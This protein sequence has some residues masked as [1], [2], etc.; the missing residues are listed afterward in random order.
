MTTKAEYLERRQ[1]EAANLAQSSGRRLGG[2]SPDWASHVRA[3][4]AAVGVLVQLPRLRDLG[5]VRSAAHAAR[6]GIDEPLLARVRALLAQAESTSFE[7]EAAAFMAKA[8]ELMTRYRIDRAVVE[9]DRAQQGGAPVIDARRCWLDDPYLSLESYLLSV[10]ARANQVRAVAADK[11]GFVTLVGHPADVD[12]TE[13]LFTSL[14]V[15]ATRRMAEI[16]A[17][18]QPAGLGLFL[19]VRRQSARPSYRRSFFVGFANRIGDR[20][21]EA[22]GASSAAAVS[23]L[24]ETFLP[25]LARRAG[26]VDEAVGK[27]F[28]DLVIEQV[29]VTDHRGWAAGAAA[30]DL[31][32]LA[33]GP[34]LAGT[35]AQ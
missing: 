9:A 12:A 15:Q 32:D 28:G 16:T 19:A 22:A 29:G 2:G 25:V 24:G 34:V 23:E 31:A 27:L 5:L 30:A 7:E 35:G 21:E 26:T 11:I 8:Q 10:V 4:L 1:A 6:P 13:I 33:V 20:L 17:A 18:G 3:V 14:L